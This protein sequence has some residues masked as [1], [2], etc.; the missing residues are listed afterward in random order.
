MFYYFRF[1]LI[2]LIT[3]VYVNGQTSFSFVVFTVLY[4]N[5]DNSISGLT[6]SLPGDKLTV[7][8]NLTDSD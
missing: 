4:C 2:P 5:R 6:Q 1:V 8:N 7:A 3:T